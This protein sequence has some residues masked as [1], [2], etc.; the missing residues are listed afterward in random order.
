MDLTP[1]RPIKVKPPKVEGERSIKIPLC[2]SEGWDN[3]PHVADRSKIKKT[4]SNIGL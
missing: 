2:C 1:P 3:C 4:K